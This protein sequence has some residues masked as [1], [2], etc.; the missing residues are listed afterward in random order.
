MRDSMPCRPRDTVVSIAVNKA[1]DN[2]VTKQQSHQNSNALYK[3]RDIIIIK[4]PSYQS[5]NAVYKSQDTAV[6]KQQSYNRA[7]MLCI[8]HGTLQ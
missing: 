3:P 1:P 2:A 5:S 4:H 8:N 6:M 7:P